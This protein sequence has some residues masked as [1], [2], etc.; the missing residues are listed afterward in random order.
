MSQGSLFAVDLFAILARIY[1]CVNVELV[2]GYRLSVVG[3]QQAAVGVV[4]LN[5]GLHGLHGLRGF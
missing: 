3:Y 2:I 1:F 4:C 5:H